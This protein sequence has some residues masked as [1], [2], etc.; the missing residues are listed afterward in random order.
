MQIL[1]PKWKAHNDFYN[2]GGEGYNPHP[3]YIN[4]DAPAKPQSEK[5]VKGMNGNMVRVS[6][7]KAGLEKDL[8]R[9]EAITDPFARQ[10]TQKH[11]DFARQALADAGE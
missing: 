4:R 7:L 6:A 2:E 5:M 11:I 8:A 1:N 9:M 3:K 10:I